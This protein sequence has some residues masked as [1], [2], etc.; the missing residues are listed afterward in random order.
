MITN[1]IIIKAI[2]GFY[3]V[4]SADVVYECKAPG[5][6]RKKKQSP[7]VG[8]YVTIE[9][10]DQTGVLKFIHPRKNEWVRPP[11]ANLDQLFFVVS[12]CE[13]PPNLLILD[14]LIA[15]A[16]HKT[17]EPIL[18]VTKSDLISAADFTELYA[19]AGFRV[20]D[21][22]SEEWDPKKVLSL[23]R[24]KVSAFCGNTGAGKSTLL[25]RLVPE[26]N[27]KTGE[28]SMK[29]GRGRHTTR[30]VEL[31]E[32]AGGYVADTPGFSTV[33]TMQYGRLQKEDLQYCFR[34][35]S[36]CLNRCKF[37]GCSHTVEK[38][39]AVL[40]KLS[41][42]KIAVSRHESYKQMY[43]EAKEIKEWKLED[44]K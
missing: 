37:T 11:L 18:I 44:K 42:N 41:E 27:L 24:D 2:S 28:T 14:K 17:I 25:N 33:D 3:Y 1:G 19:Q 29:L 20:I 23:F 22:R 34:E 30:H 13:P 26:L 35:F 15:I 16:E 9:T 21:S 43:Q 39:C 12:I 10:L 38:G 6:F 36:D 7:M 4:K 5:I 8:D 40:R 31:F 32:I